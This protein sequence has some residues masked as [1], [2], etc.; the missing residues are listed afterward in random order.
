VEN[1]Y[2]LGELYIGTPPQEVTLIYDTGSEFL[3][4]E[5]AYCATCTNTGFD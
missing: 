2:Y 3:A 1:T 4:V 5:S